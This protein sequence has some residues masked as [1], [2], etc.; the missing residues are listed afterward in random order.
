MRNIYRYLVLI[1][2]LVFFTG[3]SAQSGK[4]LVLNGTDQYM[5]IPSHADFNIT[6]EQNF[7]ITCWVKIAHWQPT[8]SAQRFIAKRDMGITSGDKSGYELWGGVSGAQFYANNAPG[9]A[10]THDNSMSGWGVSGE[11]NTWVHIGFVVDRTSGKMY[12]YQNGVKVLD[13]GTKKIAPWCVTNTSDVTVGAGLRTVA[14]CFLKGEIDNLRF[15]RKALTATEME[16]DKTAT[17]NAQTADLTAAY[18]FENITEAT[19]PDI[20]GGTSHPGTLHNYSTGGP[21]MISS[22]NL[23][24]DT[25]FT[26]R[27]NDNEVILKAVLKL[28]GGDPVA[29]N[30]IKLNM[31]G[32]TNIS[33]VESI[34]IY[35]TGSV[36]K[37]DSRN[38]STATLLG[39]ATPKD[40][41]ITCTTTGNLTFGTNY[42]WITYQIKDQ[43]NEGNKVDASLLSITTANETYNLTNTSAVGARTV[44]LARKLLFAPGD[45]GSKSYRIPA[46][47][48]AKDG[49][50]VTVT[51]KRK[52]GTQDLPADIDVVVKRSTDGGKSWSEVLII[53][54]GTGARSGFGDAG[55][56][57]TNEEGGLLCVFVGGNGMFNGSSPSTP[58]RT[59]TS[60]SLDNGVTWS[61]P[62]DIT[63]QLFGS[64]CSVE[65]RKGWYASFCASGNGLLTRSGRI[66]FVAG[67]REDSSRTLSNFIYYSD[68]NGETWNVSGRAMLYGDEAKVVELNN[69]DILMSIRNV[70]Y[71]FRH[72]NISKDGGL[73]WGKVADW[74]DM[75]V[76]NCNGDIIRYTSTRDGYD[77]DRILHTVPDSNTRRNV[78]VYLS[79][80]EGQ[81]WSVKKSICPTESGYSSLTILPDGTIGAYLEENFIGGN[82]NIYSCYYLNFSLN[83]LTDG[84]DVYAPS[85]IT[86]APSADKDDEGRGVAYMNQEG[87][88]IVKGAPAGSIV[89]IYNA[90]GQSVGNAVTTSDVEVVSTSNS[91]ESIY[92]VKI[93]NDNSH[94]VRK[95]MKR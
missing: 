28:T 30:N 79:Y 68:D 55:I 10:G 58:I 93:S 53:A 59:Y 26:G 19:V 56:V 34:K 54:Q 63:D 22:V 15:W 33:D 94:V 11:L 41:E 69:G 46:I 52:T 66:M 75:K 24:Q 70:S 3:I 5:S 44:L 78:S 45:A 60:K 27:G 37:F 7:S 90:I 95:V 67:A 91:S 80:D 39:T 25:N 2:S 40:G 62:R 81:T 32:T 82:E 21:T 23:E 31:D 77:K 61:N 87:Q 64:G 50:L 92:F 84:A 9:T 20:S 29:C 88:L 49:S 8:A 1:C 38:V 42:L 18:D 51:D 6:T 48:T 72:Y 83:W 36:N 85:G 14:N 76:V 16:S 35:S 74:S 12:L 17:V 13:S 47:I 57:R 73:T 86:I 4:S 65:A 71:G 43:V 89:E